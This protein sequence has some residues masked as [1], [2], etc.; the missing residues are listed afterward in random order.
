MKHARRS[1]LG[2]RAA[3]RLRDLWTDERATT[4]LEYAVCLALIAVSVIACLHALGRVA[5]GTAAVGSN[6]LERVSGS[7]PQHA[8]PA[9]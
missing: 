5:S 1:H 6:A 7:E 3:R 9:P 2:A 8:L 4:T